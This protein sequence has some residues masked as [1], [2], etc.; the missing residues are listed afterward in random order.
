MCVQR[1]FSRGSSIGTR[2]DELWKAVGPAQKALFP[3]D[4]GCRCDDPGSRGWP[5]PC[6]A[7][8]AKSWRASLWSRAAALWPSGASLWPP[9]P[10]FRPPP[11]GPNCLLPGAK[12]LTDRGQVVV[13]CLHLGDQVLT[14]SGTFKPI[15]AIG[16]NLFTKRSSDR[17]DESIA[18]VRVAQ[19]AISPGVPARDLYLS[20]EHALFIEGYLIAVK[21]LVDGLTIT[22]DVS[23]C[24]VIEYI[25]L[26][27]NRHEVFY[28]EGAAVE[29]LLVSGVSETADRFAQIDG[30]ITSP[31]VSYAPLLG[32]F[33]GRQ[34]A[35]AL[36]RLAVYPWI[37]VRD[38]VQVVYDRLAARAQLLHAHASDTVDAA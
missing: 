22:Q 18:P 27:F 14:D 35:I 11:G 12:I 1:L 7:R 34:E 13:E 16:R 26:V 9:G 23:A 17:W 3:C 2:Y 38:R 25:H 20:P 5:G 21:N 15:K 31:M 19:S 32:Y 37:D 24:D 29:S 33:G 4:S 28:A 36:A 30:S 6:V 10:P 8:Q